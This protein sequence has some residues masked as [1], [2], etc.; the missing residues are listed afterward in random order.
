MSSFHTHKETLLHAAEDVEVL[1]QK[2]RSM[3]GI[4]RTMRDDWGKTCHHIH[5]QVSEDMVR[6]AVVGSIKS[7]KSTFI[8][9]FLKGDYLKRGAGVVT[10]IVTRVRKGDGLKATLYFKSWDEI[11][12]DIAHA[13]VL[14][15][16]MT[17][18]LETAQFDIRD[19][20]CRTALQE[21]L[22][23]LNPESLVCNN[24]TR[25][26]N[27]VL[28]ASFL[29]GFETVQDIVSTE[30]VVQQFEDDAFARH[31][32]FVGDDALA[33]YLKDIALEI[34][35][36]SLE[37]NLE[38]AD[39]QGSDSPN[40]L[41][42]AMIQDYLL[43]TH[44]IIYVIS[45]RTGLRRADIRFLSMIKKMGLLG[46]ILFVINSDFSEHDS[47]EGLQT[48]VDRTREEISLIKPSPRIYTVSSLYNLFMELKSTLSEKDHMR[49]LQWQEER[50][51]TAFSDE[52]TTRLMAGFEAILS[53]ERYTLLLMN[54]IE[55]LHVV[56][57]GVEHWIDLNL[58]MLNRNTASAS[59]M[60]GKIQSHQGKL[61]QLKNMMK[62]TLDGAL[63]KIKQELRSD[64]D[65]FFDV[66]YGNTVT[67]VI[68]F[69]HQHG[70]DVERY[71]NA[72]GITSFTQTLY[73]VFQDFKHGI[74][75]FLTESIMPE[76]IRFVREE[77]LKLSET[78][79]AV[80]VPYDDLLQ[81]ALTEYGASMSRLGFS[82]VQ[83]QRDALRIPEIDVIKTQS[84]LKLPPAGVTLRYSA[85][86]KSEAVMKLGCYTV[87]TFIKRLLKKSMQ[88]QAEDQAH[89][90]KDGIERMKRE[91]GKSLQ[92]HFKDYQENIKF[93]YMLK[94]ADAAFQSLFDCLLDRFHA[95]AADISQI[96]EWADSHQSDK[97]QISKTL[98]SLR[99][100]FRAIAERIQDIRE[101]MALR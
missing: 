85:R 78:L 95:Y 90:L 12:A 63:Q 32:D 10:S 42:L 41:H 8:N 27:C 86:I 21:A 101:Q 30:T 34:N 89:A 3:P 77:E 65:R 69:V 84:C 25:N 99:Q 51:L 54:P 52:E 46:Q 1:L 72:S 59:E 96:V 67:S 37:D 45:S 60:V 16:G 4:S 91:T 5:R 53:H 47:L 74:D 79:R 61:L 22:N 100:Q 57:S 70:V 7:G 17:A 83:A 55:R 62:S 50:E 9:A 68:N 31:R 75:T 15:P 20:E 13:M 97:M 23:G 19:A 93:Q 28:M 49:L 87:M 35:A 56:L 36:D 14:L 11:N 39:C 44:L 33:V 38:I 18:E 58:N 82:P 6:V 88:H 48:I 98:N 92:S 2:A 40:P 24:G 43:M 80:A 76:V 66:R 29:K 73:L 81:D 26:E 94:L 71:Q 64:V